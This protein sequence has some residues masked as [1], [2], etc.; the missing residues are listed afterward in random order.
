VE[1]RRH[2]GRGEVGRTCTP[3]VGRGGKWRECVW[4]RR[5]VGW[6][7]GAGA[8]V[9]GPEVQAV[10]RPFIVLAETKPRGK[11]GLPQHWLRVKRAR[12]HG[13]GRVS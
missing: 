9:R 3:G 11:G 10:D 4:E 12:G 1:E 8:R 2:G 13:R 7:S 5:K 6:P